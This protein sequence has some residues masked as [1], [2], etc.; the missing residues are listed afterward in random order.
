MN[1]RNNSRE[2]I[3]RELHRSSHG[4]HSF[5]VHISHVALYEFVRRAINPLGPHYPL[6]PHGSPPKL[7]HQLHDIAHQNDTPNYKTW[8]YNVFA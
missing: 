1:M 3:V 2:Y 6:N 7:A 8:N 5:G 4:L